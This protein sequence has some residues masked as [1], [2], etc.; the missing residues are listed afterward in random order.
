[1]RIFIGGRGIGVRVGGDIGVGV[2]GG[3]RV[4]EKVAD[5]KGV[6]RTTKIA[7]VGWGEGVVVGA[8]WGVE[9][10]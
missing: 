5:G 6:A 4:G 8:G 3:V 7:S 9:Y 1:M 2:A 10:T